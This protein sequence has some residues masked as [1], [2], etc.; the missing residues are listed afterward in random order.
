MEHNKYFSAYEGILEGYLQ[1]R[2]EH[3]L[4]QAF[5]LGRDMVEDGSSIELAVDIH[6][7][8]MEKLKNSVFT[9][10]PD[11]ER[12]WVLPFLE[13]TTPF[14]LACPN[15]SYGVTKLSERLGTAISR[16]NLAEEELQKTLEKHT[17]II[18]NSLTGTY[19]IQNGKLEF[20]N[21]RFAE[22]Y[23][24]SKQE[25]LS[26]KPDNLLQPDEKE[27]IREIRSKI[28]T[29]QIPKMEYEARGVKKRGEIIWVQRRN[30]LIEHEGKP[31]ILGNIVD[32]TRTKQVEAQ[33]R[34][35][36][37]MEAMGTLAS[38]VAHDFNNFLSGILGYTELLLM[39]KTASDPEYETYKKIESLAR[40][41]GDLV[42]NILAFGRQTEGHPLPCN[43][44]NEVKAVRKLLSSIM[45]KG[46]EIDLELEKDLHTIN[47]DPTQIHQILL[48]LCLNAGDAMPEGGSLSI[49]NRNVFLDESFCQ[50]YP[51]LKPGNYVELS[52][53]DMG[54]GIDR[55]TISR[56]FDPFFTTKPSGK[57]TGL[58]L[59]TV[60]SLVTT[61]GGDI[62]IHS[63][64]GEGTTF[65]IYF[66]AIE[67]TGDDKTSR[68]DQEIQNG[69]GTILFVD[70]E[71]IIRHLGK[72]LVTKLGYD[73]I[74]A[75]DGEEAIEIF[76]IAECARLPSPGAGP[77]AEPSEAA[78]AKAT[79]GQGVRNEEQRKSA[80]KTTPQSL[81]QT[82]FGRGDLPASPVAPGRAKIQNPKSIL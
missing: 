59:S 79:G 65:K 3:F 70:D 20:F 23:G 39:D 68:P 72:K 57:G 37:K 8:A 9:R 47:A 77:P 60:H 63:K 2:E 13:L 38:G 62:S 75:R 21:S 1:G 52:V 24:Y 40:K 56:I 53:S 19:M 32:I 22:I 73:V 10:Y 41:A 17:A 71:D 64:P 34:Q 48:N 76:R 80:I 50:G 54:C 81:A 26:M 35:A 25:L 15:G 49:K 30:T 33:L 14:G 55:T 78:G 28:L 42:R 5:Q 27:R 67:K 16:R 6:F 46:I 18:E 44:N 31:A 4:F 69:K 29:G 45:G 74:T 11:V 12:R 51:N 36:Q 82:G 7:R 61:H 43:L 66:P 58:G